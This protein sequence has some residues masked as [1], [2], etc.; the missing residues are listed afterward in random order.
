MPEVA[1]LSLGSNIG[2]RE[3]NLHEAIAELKSAGSICA[4]SSV[5]E[6]QPVELTNQPW[7][8]NCVV[9][10][11][12]EKTPRELLKSVL[13]I[14]ADMG[15]MRLRDKGPRKIDIDVLLFGGQVIDEPGL[16]IPHP[17]MHE[18]RFVLEP[19]V[20]LAPGARHP[21]LNKTASELLKAMKE[22]QIVRRVSKE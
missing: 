11:E 9:A 22:G 3:A 16:T 10:L 12:T 21:I 1:Y 6:T 8:L 19:L 2:D 17:A 4:L 14:E 18:R 20:E 5:Y 15:R 7:F 13:S